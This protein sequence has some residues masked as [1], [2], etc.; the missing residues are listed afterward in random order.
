MFT[1]RAP[2]VCSAVHAVYGVIDPVKK[3]EGVGMRYFMHDH[4]L[5]ECLQ[6]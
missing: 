2:V 1:V 4:K 3:S 5:T 6:K